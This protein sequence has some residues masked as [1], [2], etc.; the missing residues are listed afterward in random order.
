[1]IRAIKKYW[2]FALFVYLS[3][4]TALGSAAMSE[5]ISFSP[6]AKQIFSLLLYLPFALLILWKL[7]GDL[8]DFKPTKLNIL[9]YSLAAYYVILTA[10]RLFTRGEFKESLYYCVTF[11]G[12]IAVFIM[13]R[14]RKLQM[15][16]A[17]LQKNLYAIVAF[18]VLYKLIFTLLEGNT[19][20]HAPIN[21]LYSTSLLVL[22]MPLMVDGLKQT[23]GRKAWFSYALLCLSFTL[24]LVCKSRAI[25][26]LA[27]VV[28]GVLFLMNL[29]KPKVLATLLILLLCA[30]LLVALMAW[31][32]AGDVRIALYRSF[33]IVFDVPSPIPKPVPTDPNVT[34]SIEVSAQQQIGR[35][36]DM[37]SVLFN[38]GVEQ[39]KKNILFGT[40]DLYYTYDL[41]YKTMDQTAHNFLV[42]CMIC[43]G[44]IGTV[45]VAAILFF[46]LWDCRFFCK[47]GLKKWQGWLSVL[48]ILFH[49]FALGMV[50][51]SVF[52][53]LVCPFFGAVL[54]Y[55]SLVLNPPEEKNDGLKLLSLFRHRKALPHDP[56]E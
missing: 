54:A 15:S 40:G 47:D 28:L 23:G 32:E 53:T 7:V 37:R 4:W 6:L 11:F 26:V 34:P 56:E 55:Y 51:P 16:A 2:L 44:A 8:H 1:M 33:G 12:V 52:N 10:V 22:L 17:A 27:A 36:D 39:M 18:A 38:L 13:F 35:S 24:I 31:L 50:Q 3:V 41:G 45:L 49:F 29:R 46:M 48:L 20:S 43:Y 25:V 30:V 9:Y 42:E 21:N 5:V 14:D 19:F